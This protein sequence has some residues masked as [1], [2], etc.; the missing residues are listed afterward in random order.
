MPEISGYAL[1]TAIQAV[2]EKLRALKLRVDEADADD[3]DLAD[4]EEE[5]LSCT[6]VAD[7]LRASYQ[8]ALETIGN[9]PPYDDLVREIP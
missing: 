1:V 5:L 2:D 4:L 9:M 7:E 6:K 3:D 8:D